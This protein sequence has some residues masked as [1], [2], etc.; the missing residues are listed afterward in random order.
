MRSFLFLLA[1]LIAFPCLALEN[2]QG[3]KKEETKQDET[4]KD[5]AK[6]DEPKSPPPSPV[7][8]KAK[9]KLLGGEVVE[10]SPR[11]SL[12]RLAML[13]RSA[14]PAELPARI[15]LDD[16]GCDEKSGEFVKDCEESLIL[17]SKIINANSTYK[18]K[19]EAYADDDNTAKEED[20]KKLATERAKALQARLIKDGIKPDRIVSL[21]VGGTFEKLNLGKKNETNTVIKGIRDRKNPPPPPKEE[22]AKD[23]NEK[24][25]PPTP[26]KTPNKGGGGAGMTL[27]PPPPLY[28]SSNIPRFGQLIIVLTEVENTEGK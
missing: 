1:M 15:L 17:L 19:I 10:I 20:V 24:V 12:F 21:D 5:E 25:T 3:E 6:K 27:P 14:D 2:K 28:N 23:S 18:F 26:Q 9:V 16:I 7:F 22:V 11:T 13:M 8:Y 4:K